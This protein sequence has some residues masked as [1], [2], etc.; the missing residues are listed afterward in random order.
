MVAVQAEG[1]AR[2][3][4]PSTWSGFLRFLDQRRRLLPAAGAEELA[5]QI[6]LKDLRLS[7]GNAVAVSDEAIL[8]PSAAW[9]LPDS[10]L[11]R[12]PPR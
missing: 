8:P 6:I 1:C 7:C 2:L 9:R 12:A 5:D 4:K 3:S 11:P 10:P